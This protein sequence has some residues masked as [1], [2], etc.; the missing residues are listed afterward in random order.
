[1]DS[2]SNSQTASSLEPDAEYTFF[3]GLSLP[4]MDSTSDAEETYINGL[5]LAEPQDTSGSDNETQNTLPHSHCHPSPLYPRSANASRSTGSFWSLPAHS[6][7]S[8]SQTNDVSSQMPSLEEQSDVGVQSLTALTTPF[9]ATTPLWNVISRQSISTIADS[10]H[11]VASSTSQPDFDY[12]RVKRATPPPN[13]IPPVYEYHDVSPS[14]SSVRSRHMYS[15]ARPRTPTGQSGTYRSITSTTRPFSS[16]EPY[17]ASISYSIGYSDMKKPKLRNYVLAFMLDTIPRQ[18]YHY[19][20]LCLPSLYFGRV[21]RIFDEGGLSLP[22]ISVL[23]QA[24]TAYNQ[25]SANIFGTKEPSSPTSPFW[26]LKATWEALI[27]SLLNEWKTLNIASVLLLSAILTMIQLPGA[28]VEPVILYSALASLICSLMSL[29][30]GCMYIIRFDSM[31]KT[32]R[33]IIWAKAAQE[34][35]TLIWWNVWVLLAMPAVWLAW[36]ILLFLLCIMTYIWQ[37][38][39]SGVH[40]Q[41]GTA[42]NMVPRT[43]LSALFGLAF[44]YTALIAITF[45]QYGE[46]DRKWGQSMTDIRP[47]SLV[48]SYN[49][50]AYVERRPVPLPGATTTI[51][52]GSSDTSKQD[53]HLRIRKITFSSSGSEEES[54]QSE[55]PELPI[56]P[57]LPPRRHGVPT[58]PQWG[59]STYKV[60]GLW[61]QN[62]DIYPL[63]TILQERGMPEDQWEKFVSELCAAWDGENVL[64]E[65]HRL[66]IFPPAGTVKPQDIV[67]NILSTWNHRLE[68]QYHLQAVLCKEFFDTRLDSPAWA[69]YVLDFTANETGDI[70]RLAERF[71]AVPRGLEKIVIFDP[72]VV[73]NNIPTKTTTTIARHELETH[74]RFRRSRSTVS[75]G[76]A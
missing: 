18:M 65:K 16:I 52:L 5:S 12:N 62:H 1:M 19:M 46:V 7:P 9:Q 44:V 58:V 71:G 75:S 43:I 28:S 66:N 14:T 60:V 38:V 11:D 63:P 54:L 53:E 45:R 21:A 50:A 8:L 34:T 25:S 41:L 33:A 29:L 35:K 24:S 6:S 59:G 2:Y 22:E 13:P 68:T 36:S 72:Q 30:Y 49:Y 15:R 20:L 42:P 76:S 64:Q 37:V 3:N 51:S 40:H 23:A 47:S 31:R 56:R 39:P 48:E 4:A 57:G 73:S 10:V 26:N 69:V 55:L 27:D 17:P 70:P 61:F 67:S 74:V 32:Y